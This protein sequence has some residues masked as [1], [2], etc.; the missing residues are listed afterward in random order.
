M[1]VEWAKEYVYATEIHNMD[2]N[3]KFSAMIFDL[4]F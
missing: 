1:N 3:E 4:F 2:L